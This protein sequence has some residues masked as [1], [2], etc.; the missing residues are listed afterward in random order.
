MFSKILMLA[1]L[2]MIVLG[3]TVPGFLELDEG[4]ES[5]EQRV[6]Q[7]DADCYLMCDDVPVKVLCSRNLCLQNS[8]S[9]ESYYPYQDP[10]ITFKL[11]VKNETD[12]LDLVGL[13]DSKNIF[14]KFSGEKV[15]LFS[16]GLSLGHVL[17]KAGLVIDSKL[18]EVFVNN[19]KS[20][21][22]ADYVPEEGDKVEVVYS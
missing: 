11:V 15:K 8:C 17:E 16:S 12:E 22:Y 4:S 5:A 2:V 3:F 19:E 9:E 1:L 13:S 20:Y 10:G 6:C 18:G 14:V 7:A 21:E